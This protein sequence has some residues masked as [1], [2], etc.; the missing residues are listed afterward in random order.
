MSKLARHALTAVLWLSPALLVGCGGDTPSRRVP[1]IIREP[2]PVIPTPV[3]PPPVPTTPPGP[4]PLLDITFPLAHARY[5]NATISVS[6]LVSHAQPESVSI[7]ADAGGAAVQGQIANGRFQVRDVPISGQ[8]TFTLTVTATHP[9]SDTATRRMTISR[10]PELTYVPRMVLDE[11]RSRVLLVDRHS[12]AI[13]A[14]P[15]DGGPRSIVS[16]Q[17]V[18]AGPAFVEPVALSVDAEARFLYVADDGLNALFRVDLATGD[19]TTLSGS[20]PGFFSPTELDFDPIRGNLILSD[21]TEGILTIAPAT[22]ERRTLSSMQSPGP[23]VYYFRG[24]G[25]DVVRNRILVSDSS[26]LF[27]VNPTTGA[28]TMISDGLSDPTTRFLRGITV[29]SQTGLAYVADEMT[30]GVAR[31]DLASGDRQTV[32]SSGL[33]TFN[34]PPVGSGPWLEYPEDVV[35]DAAGRLFVIG[36]EFGV[37]LM[38]VMPGGDRVLVRN[39]SLGSGVNFR[40]PLGLKFDSARR[41]L[42]IADN[43]AD[44]VAEI[45]LSNGN[46][47]LV[48]GSAESRG[49]IDMDRMDAAFDA[50][51]AQYYFVDFTTHALYG[52]RPGEAP[53]IVSDA[54][55][56][57]G[58]VLNYPAGLE[59]DGSAGVAYVIDESVVLA[60]DLATGARRLV[61]SGFISLTGLTA[62]LAN[63]RLYVAELSG[64]IYSIDVASG[65]RQLVA[66]AMGTVSTGDIAYDG[67][68]Q[69]LL[70]ARTYPAQLE[71]IASTNG[72]RTVVTGAAP[73]GPALHRTRG[74][75]IDS[76]RQIAYVTD[77]VYDG[78]IAVDLHTGCR[79]LIAK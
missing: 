1:G 5:G 76:A 57:S 21:E 16:G 17:H 74:V 46:R 4:A 33:A 52:A 18:G 19:R 68:T 28:R 35:V 66:Y 13:I 6:G 31:I 61:S 70:V 40:E 22:G 48:S 64:N 41:V 29:V 7:S 63:Q 59:I 36:G 67:A 39:A 2:P 79:Q 15:L 3:I 62:N 73:C 11:D 8:G 54:S 30:N 38:Q 9:G 20:G 58:P 32:T 26:S 71:L 53:R 56:G 60:I 42:V 65:T 69:N 24:V 55:T 27:A 43:V 51:T 37:P 45:D 50:R 77:P 23:Q 25:F 78:I 10:E 47:L 75:A 44:V 49:T 34:Y 72:A 14:S 12:A